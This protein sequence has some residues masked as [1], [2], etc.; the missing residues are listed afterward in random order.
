MLSVPLFTLAVTLAAPAPPPRAPDLTALYP[1]A[2][3]MVLGV[4]VRAVYESPLG[5][6][7]FGTDRPAEAARVVLAMLLRQDDA[8]ALKAL[9]I[10]PVLDRITRLTFVTSERGDRP[11]SDDFRLFLEGDIDDAGLARAIEAVCNRQ[12]LPYRAENAG[13]RT[14]HVAGEKGRTLR[15]FRVDKATVAVVR[16]AAAVTDILDRQAGKKKSDAPKLVVEGVRAIDRVATPMWLVVG[17]KRVGD[18]VDYT[19]MVATVA[20]G[21]NVTLRVRMEA[22]D[23]DAADRCGKTLLLYTNI[24]AMAKD[25]RM[26]TT[27]ADSAKRETTGTNVTATAVLPGKTLAEEYAKQK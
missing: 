1:E 25:N 6:T 4:E 15:V 5:R 24:C 11:D 16:T 22:P 20:L 12:E 13:E 2:A 27:L 19:R 9:A 14:I 17:E 7:V 3:W 8:D 23:K 21:D 10:D 26:F 18:R